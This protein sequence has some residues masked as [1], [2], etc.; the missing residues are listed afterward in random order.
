MATIGIRNAALERMR[1][2][3]L[4]LGLVVRLARS[5][6]IARIA[7]TAGHDFL[8]VDTQHALFSLETIGHIAQAAMGCGVATLVRVP[9]FDD[10]D[11]PKLLDA[12]AMGIVVA[13]V[14]DAAQARKIVETCQFP[15]R[16]R[17]SVQSTYSLTDYRPHP[18]GELLSELDAS[19]LVVCMVETAEGV[20]NLEDICAVDGVDVVASRLHGPARR[21][22]QARRLRRSRARRRRRRALRRLQTSRQVRRARW[23]PGPDRLAAYIGKGMRF[24]TT[25]TD[26]TYLIEAA[27][28]GPARSARPSARRRPK[29]C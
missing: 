21:H 10:P 20:A 4:A 11:I 24:H 16:G 13:D 23:R 26:I 27:R 29:D 8:F 28:G 17:R 12:G 22:G 9:R 2:G 6:E 14:A 7:K 25:Q 18:I 15:P 3:D 1:A 19:T 5:G